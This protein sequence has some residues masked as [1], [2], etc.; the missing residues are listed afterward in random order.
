MAARLLAWS[1]DRALDIR[2]IDF[3]YSSGCNDVTYFEYTS[4]GGKRHYNS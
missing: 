2:G 4:F 1:D 3:G